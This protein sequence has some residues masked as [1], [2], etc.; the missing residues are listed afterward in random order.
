MAS[1]YTYKKNELKLYILSIAY[2]VME[3]AYLPTEWLREIKE[4]IRAFLEFNANEYATC[5]VVLRRKFIA[6]N[7]YVKISASSRTDNLTAHFKV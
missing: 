1:F 4:E 5:T 6:Q 7:A 2:K 3:A